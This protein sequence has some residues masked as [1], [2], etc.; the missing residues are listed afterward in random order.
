MECVAGNI[1]G[2][3]FLAIFNNKKGPLHKREMV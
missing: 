3:M 1:V 2:V